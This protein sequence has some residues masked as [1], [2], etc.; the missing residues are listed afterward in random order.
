MDKIKIFIISDYLFPQKNGIATRIESYITEIRLKPE[1]ELTVFGPPK[2]AKSDYYVY[3]FIN[4]FNNEI[5]IGIFSLILF[6]KILFDPPDIIHFVCP[7]CF[8]FLLYVW[9]AK[10]RGV[11]I[12]S[13]HHV[14]LLYYVKSYFT[15]IYKIFGYIL[16]CL[17]YCIYYLHILLCDILLSP[18][19]NKDLL[20]LHNYKTTLITTGVNLKL[21]PYN[22]KIDRK[23]ILLYVGR[24]APE[25]NLY[26]LIN[27]FNYLKS[28]IDET[29]ELY[30]VGDG[31]EM[32]N[33]KNFIVEHNI[34]NVV[35]VGAINHEELYNYYSIAKAFVTCS[36]SE[37]F[38][39]T[40]L[41]SLSCGTPIMY[42]RCDVF[43]GLY[44][45]EFKECSFNET[46][47]DEFVNAYI[48]TQQNITHI[49]CVNFANKFTWKN[50]T[51]DL[52]N[53][54]KTLLLVSL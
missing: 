22:D 30:L 34:N 42:V 31:P 38:G 28:K 2:Y 32:Q 13:S 12:V 17:G 20:T 18:S 41:E 5:Y 23:N 46:N 49:Q 36:L 40:N 43:N 53:I 24:I 51:E 21:F 14:N 7:P 45:D 25:K 16:T 27:H 44:D 11:K 54:Y 35:F 4:P 8:P 3:G 29:L 47:H 6:I 50:A 15:G 39:F 26:T 1:Y 48:H 37:T 9:I 33:L 10:I 52:L 19:I